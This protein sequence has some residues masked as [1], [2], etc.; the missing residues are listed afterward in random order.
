MQLKR[1]YK[2]QGKYNK[3]SHSGILRK[4]HPSLL[5]ERYQLR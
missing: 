5:N 1:H 3:E 2:E 4:T